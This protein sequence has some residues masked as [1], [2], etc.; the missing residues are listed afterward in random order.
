MDRDQHGGM[1]I[2]LE[3]CGEGNAEDNPYRMKRKTLKNGK[4]RIEVKG[5]SRSHKEN[6]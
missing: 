4:W 2:R 3:E 5:D 1:K 6:I